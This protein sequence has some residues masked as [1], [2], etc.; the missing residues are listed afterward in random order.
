MDGRLFRALVFLFICPGLAKADRVNNEWVSTTRSLS[1]GNVGIASA[2]DPTT[3]AFYNP[4]ALARAKKPS[5][6]IFN[7]QADLGTGLFSTSKSITDWPK[8]ASYGSS[9]ELVKAKAGSVSSLSLSLF[10]NVSSQ[11]FSVGV[12]MRMQRSSYYNS[13]DL[14][15]NFYSRWLVV[16]SMGISMAIGGGRIRFGAAIR[17]IQVTETFGVNPDSGSTVPL[18]ESTGEGLGIGLDAGLLITMPWASLPTLGF[19]ARNVGDTAFPT[20]GFIK[21]G[22]GNKVDKEKISMTYDA[23]LSFSPKLGQRDTL[24]FAADYR[25]GLNKTA[26]NDIRHVNIGLEYGAAK[27]LFFRG[28]FSQGYWTAGIGLASKEGALDIGSYADELHATK[29]N[30]VEDRKISFRFT[31]RF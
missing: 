21:H 6:E 17:A 28:G 15:W 13:K 7:P 30:Q 9:R 1:M 25:D 3:A 14:T 8:H 26:A 23:G 22:G 18:Q 24:V 27:K 10:P 19:V 11:N 16:P 20:R 4:A 5:F 2:E 29:Y 12:L 31:R